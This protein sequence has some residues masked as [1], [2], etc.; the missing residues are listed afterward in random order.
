[1][2]SRSILLPV[3]IAGGLI[4]PSYAQ[5]IQDDTA[6][7]PETTYAPSPAYPFGRLNPAA[8]PETE[9]FAFMVGAF[10][11]IDEVR[12]Q[13][14]SKR[15]FRAIWNA[16]YFL[17]GFGIQ[18]EYW[19][20][21]FYTSNI[22]IY[23]ANAGRWKVTYFKKPGYSSGVW[24][25]QQEGDRMIMRNNGRTDGPGLTFYNI[26][27]GGFDWHSGGDD[28]NWTSSCTRRQ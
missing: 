27:E 2:K 23:D 5:S 22:R 3:L 21:T 1:M 20:P 7:D 24:E 26:S 12:Q 25:G 11:C 6:T 18:D 10:D 4:L 17:N 13:D 9:Q 16:H 28:P 19:T 14:G 15:R 8:P